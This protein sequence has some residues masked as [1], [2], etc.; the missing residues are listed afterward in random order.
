VAAPAPRTRCAIVLFFACAVQIALGAPVQGQRS[1]S[2]PT[3]AAD[4]AFAAADIPRAESLYYMAVRMRPRDPAAREELGGYLAKRGASRIAAVLLEE[5]R[6][7]GGSPAQI[8][9]QLA[10]LYESLGDWRALLNLPGAPLTIAQRRRAAWLT[11]HPQTS[12]ADSTS[13]SL[14]GTVHSDTL[15]R[16]MIRIAGRPVVATVLASDVGVTVGARVAAMAATHFGGDSTTVVLD[17][18][19][20]GAA[21]LTMVPAT[22]DPTIG[23][24]V[25]GI[26]ALRPMTIAFD[27]VN[28]R[29]YLNQLRGTAR[30]HSLPLFRE[31]GELQVPDGTPVR[32]RS[33]ASVIAAAHTGHESGPVAIDL[34]AGELRIAY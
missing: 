32:W 23:G 20:I 10:P 11:E 9:V 16:I 2:A 22:I 29:A 17:S 34:K 26:G 28:K 18:I 4:S 8:A 5:A 25:I 21:R 31:R 15:G 7:F 6:M 27:Y 12:R 24:A 33:L 1:S 30:V 19:N 14:T 13:L 3:S